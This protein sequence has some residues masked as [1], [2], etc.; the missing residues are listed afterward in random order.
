MTTALDDMQNVSGAYHKL[1]D[2]YLVKPIERAQLVAFLEKSH[3][4]KP[5]EKQE[6]AHG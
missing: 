3:L 2:G 6:S 5:S 1:A 4:L